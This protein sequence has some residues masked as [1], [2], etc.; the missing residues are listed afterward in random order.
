MKKLFNTAPYS[1]MIFIGLAYGCSSSSSS[2]SSSSE[3]SEPKETAKMQEEEVIPDSVSLT[4]EGNDNMQFDKDQME[5]YAGQVVTLTLV[6]TGSMPASSMG[7]NW[8]LLALGTKKDQFAMDA[9]AAASNSY[10]P[11]DRTEEVIANTE[12]IGGGESTTITFT[13]PK[14]GYYDY[15]CSFPGHYGVMQGSFVVKPR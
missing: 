14:A 2:E 7:H 12:V 11:Q 10:I 8:V 9:V 5:V 4:I 1:L 3:T 15:I 13:A 6:H